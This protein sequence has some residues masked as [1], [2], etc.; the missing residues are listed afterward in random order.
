MMNIKLDPRELRLPKALV[1]ISLNLITGV[2][3]TFRLTF[4]IPQL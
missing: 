2:N 3:E 4:F 1:E